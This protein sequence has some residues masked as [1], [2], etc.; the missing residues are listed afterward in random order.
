MREAEATCWLQGG[1]RRSCPAT[2]S[3]L[4][5]FR[6]VGRRRGRRSGGAG[7][8]HPGEVPERKGLEAP[9]STTPAVWLAAS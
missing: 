6:T 1:R 2:A 5:G 8:G 9:S 4:L 3:P 7:D